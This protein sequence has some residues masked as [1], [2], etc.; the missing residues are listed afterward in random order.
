MTDVRDNFKKTPVT[1]KLA[2]VPKNVPRPKGWHIVRMAAMRAVH[3][4]FSEHEGRDVVGIV[5]P[6]GS[7]KPTLAAAVVGERGGCFQLRDDGNNEEMLA[8]VDLVR[9]MFHDGIVWLRVG[10]GASAPDRRRELMQELAR[11]FYTDVMKRVLEAPQLGQDGTSYVRN[12]ITN[13]NGGK[14][15]S[16][17]VVAD[18]VWDAEVVEQLRE[19]GMR[20]LITTRERSL[21][22]QGKSVSV[23]ALTDD[24]AK[25]LLRATVQLPR[26]ADLPNE[27][28][29]IISRC[30]NVAMY[31]EFVGRWSILQTGDDGVPQDREAWVEVVRAI[32]RDLDE[33][34]DDSRDRRV[35]ILRAGF[36][37][38]GNTDV[39]AQDLYL[40]LAVLPDGHP[41]A[42]SDAAALL[43]DD[44]KARHNVRCAK[45]A[46]VTLEQ[47]AVITAGE[48]GINHMHD[49]HADFAKNNLMA[50]E[51]VRKHAVRRWT[52]VVSAPSYLC[53][54]DSFT[55]VSMWRA[56][57]RV[58]GVSWRECR[59]YHAELDAMDVSN[60]L[61]R[62]TAEAIAVLYYAEG[63]Y[64][65]AESL[66]QGVL[67]RCHDNAEADPKVVMSSLLFCMEAAQLEGDAE[68]SA[69]LRSQL[70]PLMQK[71]QQESSSGMESSDDVDK[72]FLLHV[73]GMCYFRTGELEKAE[74]LHRQALEAQQRCKLGERHPLV[75]HTM[76][77]L[78]V[79]LGDIGRFE[80]A[81]MYLKRSVDV[82]QS[83]LLPDDLQVAYSIR[84][85]AYVVRGS[86]RPGEAAEHLTQSLKIFRTKSGPGD[87]RVAVT[88]HELGR[89]FLEAGQ[90]A[91]AK[92]ALQ[93]ALAIKEA[94]RAPPDDGQLLNLEHDLESC[95]P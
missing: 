41:F 60:E 14:G 22:D 3:K 89:T 45:Q 1:T 93:E 9:E 72:C 62:K 58:N 54:V 46:I 4:M 87:L 13:G 59:R 50:N 27:A 64:H 86:K 74:S 82:F 5:G 6:S 78:G 68:K 94:L 57:E 15:L 66:M 83:R 55:L 40:A 24:E 31:V 28:M 53:T 30:D 92:A 34:D 79:C 51:A 10:R 18:D 47:W 88:L 35:A 65:G 19:T 95:E 23:K 75:A 71:L 63:D 17:L 2:P 16:C 37:Y 69:Q 26:D 48:S 36:K 8:E 70:E 73:F 21:V 77:Y 56:L 29:D 90:S 49:A 11:I 52:D 67:E 80:E 44:G 39:L 91:E 81:E 42:V 43:F 84:K 25:D 12:A 33:Q 32:D 38:L 61:F 7:G 85:L 76:Y 20:V